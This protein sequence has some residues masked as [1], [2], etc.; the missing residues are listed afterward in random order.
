M[1]FELTGFIL[2]LLRLVALSLMA[3]LRE[4]FLLAVTL[5]AIVATRLIFFRAISLPVIYRS[6][7]EAPSTSILNIPSIT[8]LS[9]AVAVSIKICLP[10]TTFAP[11]L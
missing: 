2:I 10:A 5:S 8:V 9:L 4:T 3:L 11:R 6:T 1:A 7:C